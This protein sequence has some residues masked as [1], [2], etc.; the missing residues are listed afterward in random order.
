MKCGVLIRLSSLWVGAHWSPFQRRLC[1]N[2]IP[3]V[4][5]WFGTPPNVEKL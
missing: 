1:V 4:T 5:F 2:L 3:C